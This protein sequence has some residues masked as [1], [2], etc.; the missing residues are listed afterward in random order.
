MAAH[1]IGPESLPGQGE[2]LVHR[3]YE[4]GLVPGNFSAEVQV[5][6]VVVAEKIGRAIQSLDQGLGLAQDF[7]G[8]AQG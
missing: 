5:I 7:M 1:E 6:G 3:F 2:G 8:A 4:H